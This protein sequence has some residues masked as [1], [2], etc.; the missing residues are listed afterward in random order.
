MSAR[1][2]VEARLADG[3]RPAQGDRLWVRGGEVVLSGPD[4]DRSETYDESDE[5][6]EAEEQALI[7]RPQ[8]ASADAFGAL[9][10]RVVDSANDDD[11]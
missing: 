1:D 8:A 6:T 10:P 7:E 11:G 5:M 9:D 3:W 2:D 4:R